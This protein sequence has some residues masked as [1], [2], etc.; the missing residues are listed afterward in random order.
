MAN[1]NTHLF[2]AASASGIAAVTAS[3]KEFFDLLDI[4]WFIF[5]GT[6]G[7]LLPDID[8][9]SSKPLHIL[10]NSLGV[11]IAILAILAF[12]NQYLMQHIF[13]IAVGSFLI[14]RYPLLAIFKIMTVHRGVFHSLFSAAF[15]TL[16]TVCINFYVFTNNSQFS[17]L[18]GLFLGFGF[19]VHLLLDELYGVNLAGVQLKRS[20]GTAFKLF[21]WRYKAAS[22]SMLSAAIL[23]YYFSPEYPFPIKSWL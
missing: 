1:F 20:F 16:L 2:V 5:L 15:F 18:S 12:K 9:D 4:P 8:S 11:F 19:I 21:S 10:F 6:M 22:L 3:N 23:L 13:I 14:I 17:W 7:G